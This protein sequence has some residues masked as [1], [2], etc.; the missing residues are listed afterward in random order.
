V[1]RP[2]AL[3]RLTP[4]QADGLACVLC[5]IDSLAV[6]MPH[7]PVG[8]SETGSQVFVCSPACLGGAK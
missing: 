8:H 3:T 4:E 5:G 6:N 1:D 2:I 7:R